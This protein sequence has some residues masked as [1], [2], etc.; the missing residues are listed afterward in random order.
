[1]TYMIPTNHVMLISSS[2]RSCKARK[3]KKKKKKHFPEK[4]Y[5]KTN[6]DL[7]NNFLP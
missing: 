7:E 3:T 2:K 5:E 1:M 4:Y 6:R